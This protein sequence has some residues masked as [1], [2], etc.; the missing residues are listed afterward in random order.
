LATF[1]LDKDARSKG[2]V[3]GQDARVTRPSGKAWW[4]ASSWLKA[5]Y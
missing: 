1:D 4:A 2:A 3:T 5:P